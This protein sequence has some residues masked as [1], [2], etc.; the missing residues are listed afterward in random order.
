M[1]RGH[2]GRAVRRRAAARAARARP[3]SAVRRS[4]SSTAT[5]SAAGSRGRRSRRAAGFSSPRVLPDARRR[6]VGTR[7]AQR[8]RGAPARA[9]LRDRRRRTST[10]TTRL[11][12]VR[13]ALRLR[14]GRP[15]GRA[16]RTV[17]AEETVGVAPDGVEVTTLAAR[18]ELF[19]RGYALARRGLR[20]HGHVRPGLRHARRLARR[21]R[22]ERPR[23]HL[24]R[25]RRRRVVGFSGLCRDADG[26]LED[27]LTV[28]RR[29][30]RR[31]G[32]AE[33]LKR[34]EARVG[35][36]E[37]RRGDRDLDAEG[38][39]GMRALN[40]RLGYVYRSVSITVR[41]DLPVG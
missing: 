26:A 29:A 17:G 23:G 3:A 11:A 35:R 27:G 15:P 19:A 7:A 28:V 18:P 25:P 20:G 22:G 16:G 40:E 41:A 1:E 34:D 2:A 6:G 30:W 24:R 37:R 39:E 12:R 38:N 8:A 33:A 31:R 10:A 32:L 14:G 5:S 13:A 9:R 4:P 36:G 21:R